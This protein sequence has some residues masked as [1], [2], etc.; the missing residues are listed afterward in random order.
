MELIRFT[1]LVV[2][3]FICEAKDNGVESSEEKTRLAGPSSSSSS[4]S[5]SSGGFGRFFV[6]AGKDHDVGFASDD[7]EETPSSSSTHSPAPSI[8]PTATNETTVSPAPSAP[9]SGNNETISP[10]PSAPPSLSPETPSP[11]SE[12]PTPVPTDDHDDHRK[13]HHH[14][15]M[16]IVVHTIGWLVLAGASMLAFGAFFG[17]RFRIYYYARGG[18][19]FFPPIGCDAMDRDEITISGRTRSSGGGRG[20][21]T[22]NDIIF[23]GGGEGLLMRET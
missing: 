7:K 9:P 8:S 5:S 6:P 23:E 13:D 11:T 12:M 18:L 2:V 14:H 4:S 10:A 15:W 20:S 19:V 16:K 21:S 22:L 17:N 3:L 1:I